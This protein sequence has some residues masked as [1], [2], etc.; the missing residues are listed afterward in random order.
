MTQANYND[1]AIVGMAIMVAGALTPGEQLGAP[2]A[3][4]TSMIRD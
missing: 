1:I 2:F 4:V 3:K